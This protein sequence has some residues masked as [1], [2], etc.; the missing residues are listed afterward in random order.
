MLGVVRARIW[1]QIL[2]SLP[3][4]QE[5]LLEFLESLLTVVFV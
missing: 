2:I 3:F 4:N 1:A 5:D